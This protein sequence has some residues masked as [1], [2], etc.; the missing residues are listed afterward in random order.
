L[1]LSNVGGD[2]QWN[3]SGI[4]TE[5]AIWENG[6]YVSLKS[7]VGQNLNISGDVLILSNLSVGNKIRFN[8]NVNQTIFVNGT[9]TYYFNGSD[10]IDLT[11]E[12][13]NYWASS[14]NSISNITTL[15]PQANDNVSIA[16]I[17]M[18]G[19]FT[20]TGTG[21]FGWLGS[22][23]SRITTLFVKDINFNG[24]IQGFDNGTSTIN[25]SNDGNIVSVGNLSIDNVKFNDNVN[26]TLNA[27]DTSVFYFNG[28]TYTDLTSG[29]E[30]YFA[31][32]ASGN[33]TYLENSQDKVGIGTSIPGEKLEVVGNANISGNITS[34][35]GTF[36]GDVNVTGSIYANSSSLYLGAGKISF[37]E[38]GNAF[39]Y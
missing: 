26:R 11:S 22:L 20:T 13:D 6:T 7:T 35:Y 15:I 38:S 18:T 2:L 10:Y 32:N 31:R 9:S 39:V 3:G 8:N 29:E 5:I 33:Y 34:S 28:S 14:H 27:N 12:G 25:I 23:T 24:T 37:N 21:L 16:N 1:K 36:S 17:N 19:N 30:S 4:N